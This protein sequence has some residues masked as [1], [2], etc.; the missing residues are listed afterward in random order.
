M[1]KISNPMKLQNISIRSR[2]MMMSLP[3]LLPIAV[4]FYYFIIEINKSIDFSQKELIGI[5]SLDILFPIYSNGVVLIPDSSKSLILFFKTQKEKIEELDNFG[6]IPTED[7]NRRKWMHYANRSR[8]TEEEKM[9]YF[10][11]INEY[12]IKIGDTSNLILDPDV[13]SYYLMDILFFRVPEIYNQL[14]II[15]LLFTEIFLNP[16]SARPLTSIEK[17]TFATNISNLNKNEKFIL[18]SL[19]KVYDANP[20]L[21]KNLEPRANEWLQDWNNYHDDLYNLI[22]NQTYLNKNFSDLKNIVRNG[23]ILVNNLRDIVSSNLRE[24]I[25][26]RIQ[27]L[28]FNRTFVITFI[29]IIFISAFVFVV[30]VFRSII[31]PLKSIVRR[32]EELSSGK[33]NLSIELPEYGRNEI[34][35]LS[36]AIN[37]YILTLKSDILHLKT[38]SVQ[39]DLVTKTLQ[40]NATQI[41]STSS[42]LASSTE[43]FTATLSQINNF[44]TETSNSITNEGLSI[45]ELHN[46]AIDLHNT[47]KELELAFDNLDR[48]LNESINLVKNG[49]SKVLDTNSVMDE[50]NSS[51]NEIIGIVNV[52]TEISQKTNLLAL[53][54]SI[55]AARAGETGKGFAVVADSISGL[56]IMTQ[57][58]VKKIQSIILKSQN[59][60][61]SGNKNMSDIVGFLGMISDKMSLVS[62]QIIQL[63][64]RINVESYKINTISYDIEQLKIFSEKIIS[65]N[66]GQKKGFKEILIGIQVLSNKAQVLS[67][68]AD[69][70][71]NSIN[72]VYEVNETIKSIV[73]G[74]K[75][76]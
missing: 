19:K 41:S 56:A 66:D 23:I 74:F 8:L 35:H 6:L 49:S 17:N 70:L 43:E 29:L 44:F 5:K 27:K 36:D 55:E 57:D 47:I 30:M 31:Y 39:T 34:G 18:K 32:V 62:K 14:F 45:G 22:D 73:D 15:N 13:D 59:I 37:T 11:S 9:Q 65:S 67:G 50:M 75:I 68:S 61:T 72:N 46:S 2:L 40:K 28:K 3:L 54:A 48:I 26:Q 38:A 53:N 21:K 1:M 12:L 20:S 7:A 69:D 33:A 60:V 51:T 25:S 71:H 24:I 42:E 4:L 76:E 64:Q 63:K 52:I 16:N 58:S 10:D